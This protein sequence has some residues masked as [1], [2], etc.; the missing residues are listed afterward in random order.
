M[1][2]DP[3]HQEMSKAVREI[4]EASDHTYGSRRMKHALNALGYPV[5]RWKARKLMREAGV[6]TRYR[7]K[8][9]VTTNSNHEQSVFDNVL[10]RQFTVSGPDQAYVSDIT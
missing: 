6:F 4:T 3:E 9:M 8:Y 10:E 1:Q 7:K 2:P 5:S